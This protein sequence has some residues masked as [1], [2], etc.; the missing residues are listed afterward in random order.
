MPVTHLVDRIVGVYAPD[1]PGV[2]EGVAA[3]LAEAY[4]AGMQLP[5]A[6]LVPAIGL[7][8]AEREL[9]ERTVRRLS[10]D[11][12]AAITLFESAGGR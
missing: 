1:V 12:Q 10:R 9:L 11:I 8:R 5:E 6:E 2:R 7:L 4:A 3:V